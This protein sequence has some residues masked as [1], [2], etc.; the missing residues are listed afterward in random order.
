MAKYYY[1]NVLLPEIPSDILKDYSYFLIYKKSGE[2]EY[3]LLT[4]NDKWYSSGTYLYT[5]T[6]AYMIYYA[7]ESST[8]WSYRGGPYTD[9][10]INK[11]S[12]VYWANHNVPLNS[13]TSTDIFVVGSI[14]AP[15]EGFPEGEKI[16]FKIEQDTLTSFGDQA[17]RINGTQDKLTT[18]QMLEIFEGADSPEDLSS[19]SELLGSD[20]GDTKAEI[21]TGM[22]DLIDL[23]NETTGNQD[24][25]LTDGVN[26]LVSGYG[27]GGSSGDGAIKDRFAS[28]VI[29]GK[30]QTK[31]SVVINHVNELIFN[32][33]VIAIKGE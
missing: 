19:I 1:G 6:Q 22:S 11:V 13:S 33:S 27:Q 15:E 29:G 4:S 8:T 30:I 3:R 25:N 20:V 31:K 32:S 12:S 7:Y 16:Y 2:S 21:E 28:N 23:A 10:S 26:A 18:A 17:R 24:T 5:T 9:G 14:P